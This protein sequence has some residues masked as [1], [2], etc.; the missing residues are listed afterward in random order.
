MANHSLDDKTLIAY[1][2]GTNAQRDEALQTFFSDM[3]LRSIVINLIRKQGGSDADGEDTF[4]DTMILFDRNI[5]E[6][7]FEGKS[8]LRTYFIAISK[9]QWHNRQR[10]HRTVELEPTHYDETVP[11][12]EV[13]VLSEER[14]SLI[15]EVLSQIG[16]RCKEILTLYGN[17]YSNEEIAKVFGFSSTD[18][19][20]KESYRC[21]LRMKDYV[22]SSPHLFELFKSL[23]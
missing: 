5:R 20:K 4:Q 18:A 13:K 22:R 17:S 9:W 11:S 10:Q 15:E 3:E 16:D 23:I 7:R 1:I 6:G 14:K 19:A 2:C 21:R 8:S 12:V